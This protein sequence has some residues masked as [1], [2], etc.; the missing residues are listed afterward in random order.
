MCDRQQANNY[1][2]A[3]DGILVDLHVQ[4]FC[5]IVSKNSTWLNACSRSR[6]GTLHLAR[7]SVCPSVCHVRASR[8]TRKQKGVEKPEQNWHKYLADMVCSSSASTLSHIQSNQTKLISV[9]FNCIYRVDQKPSTLH[10][11]TNYWSIFKILSLAYFA[12]N[13]Q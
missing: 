8:L 2:S 9:Q 11:S 4:R 5:G 6:G 13:L 10:L 3:C 12:D 1:Y 7:R